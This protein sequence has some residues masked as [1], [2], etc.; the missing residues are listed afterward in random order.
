MILIAASVVIV[1]GLVAL[2][3]RP[4]PVPAD[5]ARVERG[6]FQVTVDEQGQTRVRGRFVIAAPISGTLLRIPLR[7]GDR[8]QEGTVVARIV[9]LEPALL[10]AQARAELVARRN[11]AEAARRQAEASMARAR[12]AQ[13]FAAQDL[14]TTRQLL[15]R[16]AVPQ[17]Q[18][19]VAEL[20]AQSRTRELQ[21]A[22]FAARTA[23]Y[24]VEAAAAALRRSREGSGT[25][26]LEVRSPVAGEVL[27]VQ[28]ESEGAVTAGTPLLEVGDPAALEVV[29]DVLT[30]DAVDIRPG[31]EVTLDRWGGDSVLHGRVRR[32]EP[33]GFTRLSALG[34][35]EQ[36]VNVLVDLADPREKWQAL[37]D[38]YRVEAHIRV[39]QAADALKVPVTALF[40]QD[41]GWAVFRVVEGRASI[42]A[43]EIG[44]RNG[45][46]AEVLKGLE[47]G[48]EVIV[49]PG[50]AIHDGVAVKA[51][52]GV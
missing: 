30:A 25:E 4:K 51:R 1:G 49:H 24:E 16:G 5:F 29:V 3:M 44:R 13:A 14:E 22:T 36:R 46:E 37:G 19:E 34:V 10:N 38:G 11:A 21:A 43:V 27:R 41:G 50:D 45:L 23:R 2:S 8:V 31:A 33:S 40:R 12:A 6:P 28:R 18:L 48:D 20:E 39:Y 7:A 52:K 9:P 47:A 32:V 26:Q 35:E 17:R 42:R 15:A